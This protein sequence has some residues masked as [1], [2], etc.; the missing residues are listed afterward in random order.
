MTFQENL[1][2]MPDIQ[3]LAAIEIKDESGKI[4]HTIPAV[5]GKL[6]SL[7]LYYA[8]SEQ[9]QQRLDAQAAKQGLMWF[10]EYVQDAKENFGKHPNIDLLLRVEQEHLVLKINSIIR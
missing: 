3:H 10:A 6:G 9:F 4:I 7:K 2:Q 8:L 5:E 1:A